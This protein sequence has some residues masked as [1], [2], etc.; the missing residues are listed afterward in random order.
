MHLLKTKVEDL[1]KDQLRV[2][3]YLTPLGRGN[4][5]GGRYAS[6]IQI[7]LTFLLN[8]WYKCNHCKTFCSFLD[9]IWLQ[10]LSV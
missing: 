10:K 8:K 7:D 4:Y 5:G 3:R 9:V 6:N 1:L 2:E